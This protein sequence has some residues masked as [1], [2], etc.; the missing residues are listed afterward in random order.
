MTNT[1]I[2]PTRRS[3]DRWWDGINRTIASASRPHHRRLDERAVCG[4][5]LRRRGWQVD[6]FERSP[7]A[8]A[9]RGAGIMTHP[10]MRRGAGRARPRLQPRFRGAD[11]APC[12][13][14]R[15]RRNDRRT[16]LPA[17][18]RPPGTACS[19]C[20]PARSAREHYHLGKDLLRVEQ[21][22]AAASRHSSPTAAR[23]PATCWSAPTGSARPCARS[24]SPR[25]SRSM[26]AM[27]P[28]A[29]SSTSAPRRGPD[30]GAVRQP[31]CSS[32]RPASSS[33]AIP[34]PGPATICA[35]AI[36][37]GTSS[38]IAPPMRRPTCLAC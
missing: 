7:V 3:T 10:E 19:R 24:S 37:A 12:D 14:R 23:R 17:D 9:G 25:R 15:G 27:S 34:W 8:L 29:A 38:G 30:A 18:G 20:W 2:A 16:A 31:R 35:P 26:P 5:Y 13:A 28:G 1:G 33:S 4:L 32:C 21:D 36:A 11:R 6:I 22:E